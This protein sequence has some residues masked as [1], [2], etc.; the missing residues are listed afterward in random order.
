LIINYFIIFITSDI[1]MLLTGALLLNKK[2][3]DTLCSLDKCQ[4]AF[5]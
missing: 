3:I 5:R 2:I 1:M 4:L